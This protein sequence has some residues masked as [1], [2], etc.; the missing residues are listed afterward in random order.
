MM[1]ESLR[2]LFQFMWDAE[3]IPEEWL[4]ANISP[5]YKSGKRT[6]PNN[7]RMISLM[8]VV[9]KVYESVITDRL[10]AWLEQN[11]KIDEEQGGF[12][13]KRGCVDQMFVLTEIIQH[14]KQLKS[15]KPTWTAFIDFSKAY[16]VTWRNGML[17]RLHDLGV[18]GKMW[19]TINV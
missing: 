2:L 14:R 7:Y 19:R 6:Q 1:T 16:D 15:S 5:I 11:G 10:T 8:S 18:R 13:A 9:A 4:G 12:R 3:K 17:K